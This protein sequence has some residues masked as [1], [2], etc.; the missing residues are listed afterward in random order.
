MQLSLMA[1]KVYLYVLVLLISSEIVMNDGEEVV[2]VSMVLGI[3]EG[4]T[5]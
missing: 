4:V 2:V 3:G 1:L 5:R